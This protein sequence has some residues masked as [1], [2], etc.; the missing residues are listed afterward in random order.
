MLALLKATLGDF[1]YERSS[2]FEAK[3]EEELLVAFGVQLSLCLSEVV[4]GVQV[5]F[6]LTAWTFGQ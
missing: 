5:W 2:V 1:C 4:P 6:V 3:S